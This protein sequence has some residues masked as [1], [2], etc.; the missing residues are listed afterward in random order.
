M[1]TQITI[2]AFDYSESFE[3]VT[4]SYSGSSLG[5]IY[6]ISA[7]ISLIAT[8]KIAKPF[9]DRYNEDFG[10]GK[11]IKI[12][13]DGSE[14]PIA[15]TLYILTARFR[16]ETNRVNIS[17]SCILGLLNSRT[18][19]DLA[20]CVDI[21]Q[22]VTAQV[23]VNELLTAVGITNKQ[24]SINNGQKILKPLLLGQ[25]EGLINLAAQISAAS[26]YFIY[27]DQ[28]G[29]IVSRSSVPVSGTENA[30]NLE[31][32]LLT[33]ER[34]SETEL[35][36]TEIIIR[37]TRSELEELPEFEK[38]DSL[39]SEAFRTI[40]RD[41]TNR[42]ITT[43]DTQENGDYVEVI[44]DY[45]QIPNIQNLNGIV[46]EP[47]ECVPPD[48]GRLISRTT[49]YYQNS[50]FSFDPCLDVHNECE[51]LTEKL[52]PIFLADNLILARSIVEEWEY[53]ISTAD[54]EDSKTVIL[55]LAGNANVG[56]PT[57]FPGSI[58]GNPLGGSSTDDTVT[59]NRTISQPKGIAAPIICHWTLGN[60]NL[61]EDEAEL[62]L[63]PPGNFNTTVIEF[64]EI[65]WTRKQGEEW[66]GRRTVSRSNV[67]VDP[68][69]FTSRGNASTTLQE[70]TE[71]RTGLFT[72]KN[73]VDETRSDWTPPD[74]GRFPPRFTVKETDYERRYIITGFNAS[75]DEERIKVIN[76]DIFG[77]VDQTTE[78]RARAEGI[79]SWGKNKGSRLSS[80]FYT[81]DRPL[82][83]VSV[84][85]P[86]DSLAPY[87]IESYYIDNPAVAITPTETSFSGV[88]VFISASNA[89][90]ITQLAEVTNVPS[91][92]FFD[93]IEYCVFTYSPSFVDLSDT[94][95]F[96]FQQLGFLGESVYTDSQGDRYYELGG[97]ILKETDEI[98]PSL[99]GVVATE[100]R[101]DIFINS[102]G[103]PVKNGITIEAVPV[104]NT[105]P[106][107]TLLNQSGT[108]K[109]DFENASFS[110]PLGFTR[111][112]AFTKY[113]V[114][115]P[116]ES[117][118][119]SFTRQL[120]LVVESGINVIGSNS[121]EAWFDSEN[122]ALISTFIN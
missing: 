104:V 9:D 4:A 46:A 58:I 19:R 72:L 68:N 109:V 62:V 11:E 100:A 2:N 115:L 39:L 32:R 1:T 119:G 70:A 56:I 50:L 36:Y 107:I 57:V 60:N 108:C 121:L 111:A 118:A 64:E 41:F 42:R 10:R 106:L 44:D 65:I 89:G 78:R 76:L 13:I 93:G 99:G 86:D 33:R 21:E 73:I 98:S 113:T 12:S 52:E 117:F 30:K 83:K 18:P 25:S 20:I 31:A 29:K 88:G 5:G 45:E 34:L 26:G 66:E 71:A 43:I 27:Q 59:Y 40:T 81:I 35:P 112:L 97:D 28:T 24:I 102:D 96:T 48:E 37:G 105:Q 122:N 7:D 90:S 55:N 38:E 120:G 91:I 3:L 74:P 110:A 95:E 92:G 77:N 82:Q 14:A 15:G 61:L 47:N 49:N 75:S 80:N 85:E 6:I 23:A 17:A 67:L 53:D 101:Q 84:F 54:I 114:G 103:V 63:P 79:F 69:R 16:P 116:G 22:G 8:P 94:D 87:N 51:V